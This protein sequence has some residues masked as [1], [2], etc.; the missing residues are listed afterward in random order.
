MSPLPIREV[1]TAAAAWIVS[2]ALRLPLFYLS[3][4]FHFYVNNFT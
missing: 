2:F 1:L 4:L 3:T